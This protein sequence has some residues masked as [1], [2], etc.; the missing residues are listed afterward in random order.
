MKNK[1]ITITTTIDINAKTNIVEELT[2]TLVEYIAVAIANI[3]DPDNVITSSS[4]EAE[5]TK[6]AKTN[7][8]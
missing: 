1:R 4:I 6:N 5:I 7:S 2:D 3:H 8:H